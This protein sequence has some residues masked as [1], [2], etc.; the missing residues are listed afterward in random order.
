[1]K[2]P[3]NANLKRFKKERVPTFMLDEWRRNSPDKNRDAMIYAIS[4]NVSKLSD[5]LLNVLQRT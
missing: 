5:Y 3:D 2:K 4:R 1:V